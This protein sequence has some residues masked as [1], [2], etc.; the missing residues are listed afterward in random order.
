MAKSHS[1]FVCQ[2]CGAV[3][4]KWSG[5]CDACG[6]WNSIV[7]DS[8]PRPD[9]ALLRAWARSLVAMAVTRL[10]AKCAEN[11]QLPTLV[12]GFHG[13]LPMVF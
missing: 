1:Q 5:K 3:H 9:E 10:E 4:H 11:N 2:S 8:S 7:S 12:K 13:S 6:G